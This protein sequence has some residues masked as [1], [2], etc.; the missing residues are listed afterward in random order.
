[1][2]GQCISQLI[3]RRLTS[4]HLVKRIQEPLHMIGALIILSVHG[5]F[6]TADG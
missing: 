2:N 1:M 3:W 4:R 6:N 5:R